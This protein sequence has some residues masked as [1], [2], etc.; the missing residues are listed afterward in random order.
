M[1]DSCPGSTPI[2]G[3]EPRP[4]GPD[5]PGKPG[6]T[7]GSGDCGGDHH[8]DNDKNKNERPGRL[9]S[10]RASGQPPDRHEHDGTGH[11][12]GDSDNGRRGS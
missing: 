6:K 4:S 8:G 9:A 10:P 2:I 7:G 3:R 5:K 12:G 11:Q 1:Q